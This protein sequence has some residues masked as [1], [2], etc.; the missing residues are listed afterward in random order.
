MASHVVY[1]HSTGRYVQEPLDCAACGTA[2]QAACHRRRGQKPCP[3]C[4]AA[5][6]RARAD[7]KHRRR[8]Q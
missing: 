7:R 4:L 6:G 1:G 5:E 8:N 2:A 3:P